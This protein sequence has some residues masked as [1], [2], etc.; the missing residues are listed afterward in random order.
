MDA[1]FHSKS[2]VEDERRRKNV[3][4]ELLNGATAGTITPDDKP[5]ELK[6]AEVEQVE[7]VG[8]TTW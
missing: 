6:G 1:I 5:V 8:G 7:T 4:A 3:L 2:S